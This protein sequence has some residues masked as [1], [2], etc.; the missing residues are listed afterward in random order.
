M[1]FNDSPNRQFSTA[2]FCAAM[3]TAAWR[4][5]VDTGVA[6]SI[7]TVVALVLYRWWDER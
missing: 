5:G 7:S 4:M 3:A 1:S 6:V 2:I